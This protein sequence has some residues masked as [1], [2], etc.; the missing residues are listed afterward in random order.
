MVRVNSD[1][2]I[3]VSCTEWLEWYRNKSDMDQL[4]VLF[5]FQS[6]DT[7]YDIGEIGNN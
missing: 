2:S 6:I 4:Y 7:E 3:N 5:N 1:Q